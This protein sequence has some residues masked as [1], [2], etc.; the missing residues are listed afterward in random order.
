MKYINVLK[1]YGAK[2]AVASAAVFSASSFADI[3]A[4]VG[5]TLTTV[6]ADALSLAD[7]VWPVIMAVFGS[8][9]LIKLFKRY[10]NKI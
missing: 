7:L 6:Q 2:V 4:V 5:T 9:L 8:I 10:G 1:R 3:P